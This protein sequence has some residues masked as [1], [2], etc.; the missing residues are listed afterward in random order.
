MR[1]AL[2]EEPR[3][4]QVYDPLDPDRPDLDVYAALVDELRARSV[5]DVGCGTGTFACLLAA[6]GVQMVAVDP[7]RASLDVA[8]SKPGA[9][10]VRWLRGDATALPAVRVDLATM[11]GN[12]AQVFLT[13]EAWEAALAGIRAALR[14]GGWLVF[15]T[16]DPGARAW[17]QWNR[18]SSRTRAVLRDG[19]TVESWVD[20]VDVRE[21]FV[22]FRTTF[23]F[24]ADGAELT[25]ESTLRF[26]S[27]EELEAS[28][29]VAGFKV[30]EVRA[31]PDRPGLELVFIARRPA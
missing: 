4:A 26:W 20:V 8:R 28:L 30:S 10:H 14:P 1:D 9:E 16:R 12:V 29:R 23:V 27:Q 31:A 22:S 17:L 13:D 7:A 18:E 3:L 6:R 2:F 21:P 24:S 5:L 25:S 15:E 19:G 11:T